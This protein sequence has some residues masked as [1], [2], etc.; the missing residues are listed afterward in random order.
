MTLPSH[1]TVSIQNNGSYSYTPDANFSGVDSLTYK[2]N[3]GSLYSNT[4]TVTINIFPVND[5]PIATNDSYTL[6]QDMTF[7]VP[8][9]NNDS[10]VDSTGIFLSG[11]TIP[12]HGN[13]LVAGTGFYYTPSLGYTGSDSFTYNIEDTSSL[14]S[15]T[16]TVTLNVT[17]TNFAPVASG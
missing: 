2:A 16:A 11:Y 15:N 1:G 7:F 12:T 10:D 5:A 4:A 8:V 14:L 6:N 13:V 9:M 17:Q 3:D